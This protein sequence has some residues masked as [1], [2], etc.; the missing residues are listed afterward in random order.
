MEVEGHVVGA[1]VLVMPNQHENFFFGCAFWLSLF[2]L[3]IL[4]LCMVVKHAI[5]A[6]I[7]IS[8]FNYIP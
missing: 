4:I 5:L 8:L 7:V 1:D 3:Y 6:A 2:N